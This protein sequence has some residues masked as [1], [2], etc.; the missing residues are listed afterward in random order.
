ML[1]SFKL[2]ILTLINNALKGEQNLLP[3]DFDYSKLYKFSVRQQIMPLIY[4][5]GSTNPVFVANDIDGKLRSST[6]YAAVVSE[7]Q[8]LEVNKVCGFFD[9][10]GIDYMRLKGFGIKKLY[11]REEMRIMGDADILIRENQMPMIEQLMVDL[12]YTHVLTSDHEWTWVKGSVKIELHKR[13]VPTYSK[14]FYSYFGDGW[15]LAN[16]KEENR[17]EYYMKAEDEF[18]YLFTHFAKH[19][20][21]SGIGIK[22]TV[23]LYMFMK[24]YK[25]LDYK[26][27][28]SSFKSLGLLKF[29]DN[30]CKMLDVWFN[31]AECDELSEFLTNKIFANGAY[32]TLT[33]TLKSEAVVL[34]KGTNAKGAKR[35]KMIRLI[36]PTYE[37]MCPT[38]SW[39]K[40]KPWLLPLAWIYRFIV[41]LLFKRDKIKA[42]KKDMKVISKENIDAYQA[43]LNFVGLD[44]NYEV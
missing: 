28:R 30:I 1:S 5:G 35:K 9:E 37:N 41:V 19:Y 15:F 16:K 25:D 24:T 31:G 10:N 26:Y 39:I 22:H 14:D 12:G 6:I 33:A 11:P 8:T 43:E 4:Y 18:V 42:Y 32:G 7:H 2:G 21:Y 20:R 13:L 44:F 27:M 17:C 23:D 29:Y 3:E 34:A 38:Y 40:G 36:F